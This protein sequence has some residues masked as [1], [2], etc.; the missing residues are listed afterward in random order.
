MLREGGNLLISDEFG[1]LLS[2]YAA[3]RNILAH[4][5]LDLRWEKI[6]GFLLS[7]PALYARF[8]TAV[9]QYLA[10]QQQVS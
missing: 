9:K 8:V 3:L 5:Y 2:E 1:A 7:A 6:H 10:S 4:Q